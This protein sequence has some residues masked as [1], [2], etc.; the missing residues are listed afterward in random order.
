MKR[1]RIPK[2]IRT[3]TMTVAAM[4]ASTLAPE[5][6]KNIAAMID[7][8]WQ[9]IQNGERTSVAM[10][11]LCYASNL[12]NELAHMGICSD[13]E[14][15]RKIDASQA[16]L[17]AIARGEPLSERDESAMEEAIFIYRLQLRFC[18]LAEFERA[19][20]NINRA[21]DDARRGVLAKSTRVIR[22]EN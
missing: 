16:I 18:S 2:P 20:L 3:D 21:M 12:A 7:R 13:A 6:Q 5:H 10:S 19:R 22:M 17:E 9:A 1:K 14:S 11:D 8:S 4:G 15:R